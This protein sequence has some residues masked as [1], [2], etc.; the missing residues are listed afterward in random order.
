MMHADMNP[1]DVAREEARIKAAYQN[2]NKPV[3]YYSWFDPG[4]LLLNQERE[5]LLL[6]RLRQHGHDPLSGRRLLEIGCGSGYWLREF[7]KWGISPADITG[8][9]IRSEELSLA[10]RL[11]PE[12]VTF[13]CMNGST[14]N[15]QDESFDLILQSLV[16]TSV[17]D[18]RMRHRMADEM[19][20]VVKN[21]G[22]IIWYDFFVDN[23]WNTNVRGVR[24]AEIKRLFPSCHIE[25]ERVS[26]ALPLAKVLAPW[27]W[28]TCHFLSSLRF[29]N[30]HYLG[31]IHKK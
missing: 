2:I 9:D 25:L 28:M 29:L 19:L 20:R 31:V 15:F 7:I 1:S 26:L 18:G 6:R 21:S 12:G 16:F 30:T 17:L 14:L 8:I 4:N 10:A 13:Q 27:S 22:L 24:K 23:P 5:T 3:G 11:C